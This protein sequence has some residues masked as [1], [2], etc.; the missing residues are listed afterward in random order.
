MATA[1]SS[2]AGGTHKYARCLHSPPAIQP[3]RIQ[4]INSDRYLLEYL[5]VSSLSRACKYQWMTTIMEYTIS[6]IDRTAVKS[7]AAYTLRF[8]VWTP[9]TGNR[10]ASRAQINL[11]VWG[12]TYNTIVQIMPMPLSNQQWSVRNSVCSVFLGGRVPRM[13]PAFAWFRA[14]S[15]ILVWT[16][17]IRFHLNKCSTT[18]VSPEMAT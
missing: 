13:S 8:R 17:R 5:L 14:F 15:A 2:L 6:S 12:L 3:I 10:T 4:R 11:L 9:S 18:V 1:Q 7:S 16:A